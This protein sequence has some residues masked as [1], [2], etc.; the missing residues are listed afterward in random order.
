ML[1][2]L[3]VLLVIDAQTGVSNM[4]PF[5]PSKFADYAGANS[6]I[7]AVV[8]DGSPL[9]KHHLQFRSFID[10]SESIAESLRQIVM[11]DWSSR[12]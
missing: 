6:A 11:T 5:L 1:D 2:Q 9:S 12:A 7:W 8:E 3:E 4:N 10:N